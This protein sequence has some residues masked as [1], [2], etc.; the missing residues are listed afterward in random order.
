MELGGLALWQGVQMALL[1]GKNAWGFDL[2]NTNSMKALLAE[3]Q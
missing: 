3:K 1:E 2:A